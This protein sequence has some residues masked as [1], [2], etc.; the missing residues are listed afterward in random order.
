M[1]TTES[2]SNEMDN[3]SSQKENTIV[4]KQEIE[5]SEFPVQETIESTEETAV[6][7]SDKTT[8]AVNDTE[9]TLAAPEVVEEANV[10]CFYCKSTGLK[11]SDVFCSNCRFPQ[12]GTL[13]QQK[14][15][16]VAIKRKKRAI[17][18]KGKSIA[19]ARNVLFILAAINVIFGALILGLMQ[20]DKVTMVASII[21]AAVY[22]SLGAWSFKKPFAA[23][24][25]GFL[26]YI[27]LMAISA[28]ADPHT[29]YQGLIWKVLIISAFVYGYKG[30]KDSEKLSKEL[31]ELNVSQD[32]SEVNDTVQ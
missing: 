7:A 9:E 26:F 1:N 16:M 13:Q 2:T 31:E 24:I 4:D 3:I 30:V 17:E 6:M 22:G 32:L 18:E 21:A 19:K 14:V 11:E 27:T 25:T 8:P 10:T 12:G 5:S 29:I 23:I 20:D 28:I 15:F